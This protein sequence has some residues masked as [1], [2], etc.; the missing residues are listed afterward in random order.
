MSIHGIEKLLVL[1]APKHWEIFDALN[2][3]RNGIFLLNFLNSYFFANRFSWCLCF[4]YESVSG[5][6]SF[7]VVYC[8]N[9]SNIRQH[10]G[11]AWKDMIGM[12]TFRAWGP[13]TSTCL[14]VTFLNKLL[15]DSSSSIPKS[16]NQISDHDFKCLSGSLISTE[17]SECVAKFHFASVIDSMM[18]SHQFPDSFA[19]TMLK[20]AWA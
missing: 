6:C 8:S 18:I 17:K 11:V 10:N 5:T 13:V 7:C 14:N 20:Y 16:V 9:F 1:K 2:I 15:I 12:P 19:K 3:R 4:E